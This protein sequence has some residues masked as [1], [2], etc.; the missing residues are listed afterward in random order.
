[1]VTLI[2]FL[3]FLDWVSL[4]YHGRERGKVPYSLLTVSG[5][6]NAWRIFE[7]ALDLHGAHFGLQVN[8]LS[9]SI[10][11]GAC[12]ESVRA[13]KLKCQAQANSFSFVLSYSIIF[14]IPRF[15]ELRT[16][17]NYKNT[18]I[19]DELQDENVTE[20]IK[21]PVVAPTEFRENLEYSRDYVLIAN[22]VALGFIPILVLIV[23]NSCI[24]RTIS[25][26]TQRHNAISSNQRR[27]HSVSYLINLKV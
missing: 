4:D 3:D 10:T 26:A 20:E 18:T 1:M 11:M 13:R 25:K 2:S 8:A 17:I 9:I 14:N 22:S 7:L 19:F 21:V 16:E 12:K 23:L 6:N 24:F 27:D 5:T 15:F